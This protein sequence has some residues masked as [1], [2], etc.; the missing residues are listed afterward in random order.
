LKNVHSTTDMICYAT[1]SVFLPVTW[2]KELQTLFWD[3][4]YNW[5][6]HWGLGE[7]KTGQPDPLFLGYSKNELEAICTESAWENF[8]K[9]YASYEF[10]PYLKLQEYK[11]SVEC[12]Y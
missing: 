1:V 6:T 10:S 8:D 5:Q 2:K 4:Q 12:W 9:T 7:N 11:K 3:S